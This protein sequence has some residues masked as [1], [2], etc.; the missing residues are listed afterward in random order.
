MLSVA[1]IVVSAAAAAAC[2]GDADCSYNG[3]CASGACACEAAWSGPACGTLNLLPAAKEGGL[4][5]L[6]AKQN[7]TTWGGA[8]QLGDDGKYHMW[9]SEM[10]NHCALDSWA[11]NSQVVHAVSDTPAGVY[12]RLSVAVENEAHEPNVVRGPAGEYVMFLC[13]EMGG[14]GD[15][16]NATRSGQLGGANFETFMSVA[17]KP[18][19][20]WSNQQSVI[21]LDGWHNRD[22]NLAAVILEDGSLVG[23]F[24]AS[25]ADGSSRIHLATATKYTD[26]TTWTLHEEDLFAPLDGGEPFTAEDP[27]VYRDARG[28]FHAIFHQFAGCV[29]PGAGIPACGSHAFS[30]DGKAWTYGGLAFNRTV[31]FTDGSSYSFNR[32]E[33][34]HIVFGKD[35]T[36]P[37]A[38]SS[39]VTYDAAGHAYTLVQPI[40]TE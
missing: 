39:G 14:G 24:R 6:G 34:P 7:V 23:L 13:A 12:T 21:S 33:R 11:D 5:Q 3:A 35:G 1:A 19:G 16:C 10:L 37:L 9:A 29:D 17:Q 30:A 15:N 4:R 27:F 18:E 20:P 40:A 32:R 8:V 26:P 38:L 36:T 25:P 2:S 31:A 28:R 22:A